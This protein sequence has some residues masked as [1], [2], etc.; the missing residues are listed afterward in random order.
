M[1]STHPYISGPTNVAQMIIHLRNVFPA[2]VTS[3]TVKKLGLAPKNESFVINA[4]QFSG[5]IDE[6]G[7]KTSK[8]SD[9]FSRHKDED[10]QEGF[11]EMVKSAYSE[12]FDLHGDGAWDLEKDDLIGFFRQADQTSGVIGGRQAGLFLV[13]ATLAGK[14]DVNLNKSSKASDSS[15]TSSA[16]SKPKPAPKASGVEKAKVTKGGSVG[17]PTNNEVELS[18]KVEINLPSDASAETYDNIF[19][20]IRTHLMNG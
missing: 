18:V 6:E 8:A 14:A 10:F 5:V 17:I 19:K 20:S 7:K 3:E 15:K 12:L 11:A 16:A 9:V 4:L 1:A 13:F 2:T